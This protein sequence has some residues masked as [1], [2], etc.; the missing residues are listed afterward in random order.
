ML[1]NAQVVVKIALQYAHLVVKVAQVVE[2]IA[3]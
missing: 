2:E 1:L 3:V